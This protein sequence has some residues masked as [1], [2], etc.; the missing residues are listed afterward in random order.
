MPAG[1]YQVRV[2]VNGKLIPVYQYVS[3]SSATVK[4]IIEF[5]K[6]FSKKINNSFKTK[7]TDSNTP[8]ITSISPISGTPGSI[9]TINGD[10][11]VALLF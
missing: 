6:N 11:K 10:F 8:K 3:L 1:T 5:Q 2:K 4:V 9:I 7:V